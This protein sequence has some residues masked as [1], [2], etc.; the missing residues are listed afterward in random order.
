MLARVI[1]FSRR[2]YILQDTYNHISDLEQTSQKGR[3][4]LRI[5]TSWLAELISRWTIEFLMLDVSPAK[6]SV[7]EEMS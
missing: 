7:C 2:G 1:I 3:S 5:N 4:G 6:T